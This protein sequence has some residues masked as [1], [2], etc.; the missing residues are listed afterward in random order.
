M[1]SKKAFV[2]FGSE[3]CQKSALVFVRSLAN[4]WFIQ[5]LHQH[6]SHS[7]PGNFFRM[8]KNTHIFALNGWHHF[9]PPPIKSPGENSSRLLALFRILGGCL[10]DFLFAFPRNDLNLAAIWSNL[11]VSEQNKNTTATFISL[12]RQMRSLDNRDDEGLLC[13]WRNGQSYIIMN[14]MYFFNVFAISSDGENTA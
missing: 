12:K 9:F 3:K 14:Y 5:F 1:C 4:V 13:G 11:F 7:A 10:F 2:S 8:Q 6:Y